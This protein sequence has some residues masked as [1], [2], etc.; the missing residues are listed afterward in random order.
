MLAEVAR[1]EGG[2]TM[3]KG[4]TQF[5]KSCHALFDHPFKPSKYTE[6]GQQCKICNGPLH[7]LYCEEQF[8]DAEDAYEHE[9]E[10]LRQP[11]KEG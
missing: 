5:D 1:N 4:A 3:Q 7:T 11:A 2:I 10:W 6:T 9:L 8:G